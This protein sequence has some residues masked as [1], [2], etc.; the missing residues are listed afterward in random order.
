MNESI[1]YQSLVELSKDEKFKHICLGKDE[2]QKL[3]SQPKG[4]FGVKTIWNHLDPDKF[5]DGHELSKYP[6]K[7]NPAKLL[8]FFKSGIIFNSKDIM[9][10]D[11][12]SILNDELSVSKFRFKSQHTF[13]L[14]RYREPLLSKYEYKYS[15]LDI[16]NIFESY[17]YANGEPTGFRKSEEEYQTYNNDIEF[18]SLFKGDRIL[19]GKFQIKNWIDTNEKLTKAFSDEIN[20]PY[21]V[22]VSIKDVIFS[23]MGRLIEQEKFKKLNPDE[24]K[25][26]IELEKLVN[27]KKSR[28][29]SKL[30]GLEDKRVSKLKENVKDILSE[31][32]KDGNGEVDIIEGSDFPDLLREYQDKIIEIDR[33]YIQ[34]F[35]KVST[36]IKTRKKNIQQLFN[37]VKLSANQNELS[38][39]TEII[40]DSIHSY[41]LILYHSLNMLVSL[42]ENDMITFYEIYEV[43]DNLN[44]F[45]SKYER[46]LFKKLTEIEYD[47]KKLMF[48]VRDMSNKITNSIQELSYNTDKTNKV[49]EKNLKQINSTTKA[50]NLIKLINTYQLYKLNKKN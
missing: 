17:R 13:Y 40:K 45:D 47:L 26:F 49:L 4:F 14:S 41:N 1:I 11:T 20:N 19:G 43:F 23:V 30:K 35:I 3:A 50:G 25:F 9:I 18:I 32:D 8:F 15:L 31:L 7:N 21:N 16:S 24:I 36:Y 6:D 5:D 27:E 22:K 37:S 29:I 2:Y 33:E 46:D 28:L 38:E 48:E 44:M 42:S 10:I 12:H 39:Y 34:K